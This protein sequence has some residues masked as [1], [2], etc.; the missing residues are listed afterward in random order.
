MSLPAFAV[1][2]KKKCIHGQSCHV[3]ARISLFSIHNKR[4]RR[5]LIFKS[6]FSTNSS[7]QYV[8]NNT[9]N[10]QALN[11]KCSHRKGKMGIFGRLELGKAIKRSFLLAPQRF[12][13]VQLRVSRLS[14][15]DILE[16]R[17]WAIPADSA[18]NEGQW[19][20]KLLIINI[21]SCT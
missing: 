8:T 18:W 7:R 3:F 15:G 13:C 20:L 2:R 5:L 6:S 16:R 19:G 12:T 1:Q 10:N 4:R 17:G 14:H 21:Q 11:I 9:F